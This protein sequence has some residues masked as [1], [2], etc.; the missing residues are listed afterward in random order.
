[1]SAREKGLISKPVLK[2]FTVKIYFFILNTL[3]IIKETTQF[4]LTGFSVDT[5]YSV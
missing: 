2:V 5:E 3:R 1:M 4:Y